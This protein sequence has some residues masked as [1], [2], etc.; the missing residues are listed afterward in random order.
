MCS[1]SRSLPRWAGCGGHHP[2]P[3]GRADERGRRLRQQTL[4]DSAVRRCALARETTV[5]RHEEVRLNAFEAATISVRV[6][7]FDPERADS[8]RGVSAGRRADRQL[9]GA[10]DH[11]SRNAAERRS[12]PTHRKSPITY[13][14]KTTNCLPVAAVVLLLAG[15]RRGHWGRRRRR[16]ALDPLTALPL[17]GDTGTTRRA[18]P[19]I[20]HRNGEEGNEE[21]G[22]FASELRDPLS[23]HHATHVAL[24]RPHGNEVLTCGD[25]E[26]DH[27]AIVRH[28]VACPLRNGPRHIG[29]PSSRLKTATTAPPARTPAENC[30]IREFRAAP[31]RFAS[32]AEEIRQRKTN[33]AT[34]RKKSAN[35][36][37]ARRHYGSFQP[38]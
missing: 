38:S 11:P 12:P 36:R 34:P 4:D 17:E 7:P 26:N 30:R 6:T 24:Q 16:R 37:P 3:S 14:R 27:E 25:P 1:A 2:S 31:I 33:E 22:E 8:V 29:D 18:R 20:L 23:G 9:A 10:A 21:Q 32:A 5:W 28:G 35:A 15:S 13:S 19:V